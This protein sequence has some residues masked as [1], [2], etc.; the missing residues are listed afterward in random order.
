MRRLT[1]GFPLT[2]CPAVGTSQRIILR[3]NYSVSICRSTSQQANSP[4]PFPLLMP[5]NHIQQNSCC[6][7]ASAASWSRLSLQQE[8]RR[9]PGW[10]NLS[11]CEWWRNSPNCRLSQPVELNFK[12]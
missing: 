4:I 5:A 8:A 10:R 3:D 6:E 1:L 9:Q 12:Y 2:R 11:W 7:D